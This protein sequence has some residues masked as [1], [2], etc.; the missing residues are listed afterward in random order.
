M[1]FIIKHETRSRIRVRF[2]QKKMSCTQAD[3]IQHYFENQ[4]MIT[5][6]KVQ[7]RTQGVTITYQG[8]RERIL[9]LLC[10]FQ[11]DT[12]VVPEYM[13]DNTGRELNVYYKEKLITKLILRVGRVLFLP[14]GIRKIWVTFR[15]AQYIYRGLKIL[16]QRK[17]EVPVLDAIA[18]G[19]SIVRQDFK[20]IGSIMF[21]LSIGELLEEWTHKKSVGDLARCM[22]LNVS[23]VWTL[24]DGQEVLVETRQIEAD[25]LVVVHVGTMIPFDGIVVSGE[26]MVNQASLTGESLPIRKVAES[27]VYAGTVIEEGG[28]VFRVKELSGSSKF[29]KI[30]G[31][32]EET[33]KLKSSVESKAE[34]L[35][36]ALVPYT[37]F[38]SLATWALTRNATKALSVL[39]VDFSCALKLAMPITVLSA[40]RELHQYHVVVKGGKYLEAMA[41]ADTI[42]F[43]KTGTLTKAKPIVVDVVSFCEKSPEEMLRLAACLEEHFPHSMAK[44]VVDAAKTKHLVHEEM[45]S[46]VE[47]VVAHGISTTVEGRKTVIGSY[48][49]IFEDEK[50]QIPEGMQERFD[51]LPEEY[52]H[53]Y[54]AIEGKLVAVICIEDPLRE[55]SFF[56]VE[57]LKKVGIKKVVMMTGDSEKTARAIASKVGVDEYYSEVLPEDKAGFVEREKLTGRKVIMIGDGINDSPAL[58]AADIG[59]AISDGA[60]I[61]RQISDITIAGDDLQEIVTLKKVSNALIKRIKKNFHSIVG[62]NTALIGLGVTGVVQPTTS[63]WFHNAST[64]AISVE[65]MKNLIQK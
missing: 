15:A 35:A 2:I 8:D 31:M 10:G 53:L 32:I 60:A 21:I 34:H 61:A 36:D 45:H 5:S 33:E 22:S 39:M 1:R 7:E 28:I 19:I 56:I 6:V 63:A 18:I 12:V 55:E 46:K 17:I 38:G 64:L 54:L 30:V 4:P 24:I 59:I 37:L 20:T 27:Y 42:V 62:I 52:S 25:D 41:E 29:E 51:N 40:I 65:S 11:Y 50:C 23:H 44:A 43:D 48:H 13:L 47:Y 9:E 14:F 16:A 58:S 57:E 49:F 3:I 26:A